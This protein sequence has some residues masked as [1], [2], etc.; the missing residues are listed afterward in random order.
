[1]SEGW[2]R[3]LKVD[4]ENP[5]KKIAADAE[6]HYFRNGKSL[7]KKYSHLPRENREAQ[8]DR[9]KNDHCAGC[10]SYLEAEKR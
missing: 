9:Q 5:N 3:L 4:S 2:K 8:I 6:I 10:E 1:M 7:C